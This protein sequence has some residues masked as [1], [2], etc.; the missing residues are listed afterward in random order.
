M[1]LFTRVATLTGPP[2]ATLGWA[3]EM[4]AFVNA[5][6]AKE[7]GL[8]SVD[9]GLPLGT[10]AWSTV[11]DGVADLRSSFEG[12][13]DDDGYHALVERGAEYFAVPAVDQLREVI[14][15]DLTGS[16]PPI[17]AVSTMTTAQISNGRYEEAMTWGAE[18]AA[19]V[20][21]I[22][23]MPTMFLA[24]MFGPF[25]QVTWISGAPD[26]AAADAARQAVNAD[27]DYVKRLGDIGD[28]F[29]PGSGRQS[30]ATRIA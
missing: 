19:H 7:V 8:W 12:L 23:S 27:L 5:R 21:Q 4:T 17:G 3:T 20:Q 30:M 24:D 10:I 2:R 11:V 18:M 22:T 1:H 13:M 6:T 14:R 26:A 29:L 16:R 28:M 9:F 15:G 25:G